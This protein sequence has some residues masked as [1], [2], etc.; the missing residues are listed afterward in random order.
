MI[1]SDLPQI[2]I[3]RCVRNSVKFFCATPQ[4]ITKRGLWNLENLK[5]YPRLPR[6]DLD[7]LLKMI[8]KSIEIQ[9]EN[10]TLNQP[11]IATHFV[12]IDCRNKDEISTFGP[13]ANSVKT[14]EFINCQDLQAKNSAKAKNHSSLPQGNHHFK[15]HLVIV[16]NSIETSMLLIENY[17]VP[18]VCYLE[19]NKLVPKLLQ[20]PF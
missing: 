1:F 7:D 4:S 10:A 8:E 3:D 14:E 2:D 16:V 19:L 6:I 11:N 9:E 17:S 13:I 12:F 15:H 20:T 18:R 5:M